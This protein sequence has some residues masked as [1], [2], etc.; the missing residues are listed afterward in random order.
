MD[1]WGKLVV[2]HLRLGSIAGKQ[3][4]G[5]ELGLSSMEL[6]LNSLAPGQSVPFSHGHRQNEEL[7]LFIA[8][9]GQM[10]LDAQVVDVGPGSAV[11]V[12]P[13]VMR[14]WR[15]NGTEQLVCICIQAREGSLEQATTKDGFVSELP[16]AWPDA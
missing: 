2:T 9:S 5:S 6:S 16:P 4:L 3:F 14:T 11:R 12:A 8:G 13:P 10:L 7:Y 15:N 1:A